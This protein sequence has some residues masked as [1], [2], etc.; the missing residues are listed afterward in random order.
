[1]TLY[2]RAATDQD[3]RFARDLTRRAM[4]PYYGR[5]DLLWLDEG[6]DQAWHWRDNRLICRD[7]VP[8]G[9]ISLSRDAHALFIREV[10]LLPAY[11][12]QGVGHWVLEQVVR[13]ARSERLPRV[14]LMVFKDNPAQ[15]LYGRHG[16]EVVGEQ[17]SF[18][19]MERVLP[20]PDR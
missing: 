12:G 6:F 2:L 5:H 20:S 18:L 8:L 11:R 16:F 9:Y 14:R 17:D 19:R 1:M 4:L 7:A 15:R 13:Q 3:L 10:H